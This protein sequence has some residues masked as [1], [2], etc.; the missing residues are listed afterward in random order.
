MLMGTNKIDRIAIIETHILIWMCF[1]VCPKYEPFML[2]WFN[3]LTNY[4]ITR[5]H[6][7]SPHNLRE[8][9]GIC[10]CCVCTYIGINVEMYV[11]WVHAMHISY[12]GSHFFVCRIE[13]KA[14][15]FFRFFKQKQEKSM[16]TVI[17]HRAHM[18]NT[19]THRLHSTSNLRSRANGKEKK[20]SIKMD[21]LSNKTSGCVPVCVCLCG[22][23]FFSFV[24]FRMHK[25]FETQWKK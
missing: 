14:F 25:P 1:C 3:N 13:D 10:L 20:E 6:A 23:T 17:K 5:S 2:T 21:E 4:S 24:L 9:F 8:F 15:L 7:R 18:A 11:D 16:T 12:L 19:H 22:Y